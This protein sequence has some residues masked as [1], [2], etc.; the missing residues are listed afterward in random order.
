MLVELGIA[1]LLSM[2]AMPKTLR[3]RTIVRPF[4]PGPI[5]GQPTYCECWDKQAITLT[6]DPDTH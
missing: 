3:V 5:A 6:Y 1:T 2:Y 4:G